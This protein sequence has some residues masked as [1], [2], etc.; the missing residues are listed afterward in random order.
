MDADLGRRGK[1]SVLL[2]VTSSV[3]HLMFSVFICNCTNAHFAHVQGMQQ[4]ER[5]NNVKRREK[6]GGRSGKK[7]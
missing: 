4:G 6:D 1:G 5:V 2:L 7:R 3:S